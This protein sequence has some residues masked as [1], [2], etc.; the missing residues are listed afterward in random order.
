MDKFT[1]DLEIEISRESPTNYAVQL[2]F[3][4]AGAESELR[5]LKDKTEAL[6]ASALAPL[7]DLK[8]GSDQ[9]A[10]ILSEAFFKDKL[11]AIEFENAVTASKTLRTA[12]RI[13]LLL[14]AE[15]PE[16]HAIQWE[17]LNDVSGNALATRENIFFSRYLPSREIHSTRLRSNSGQL[18]ALIAVSNP[19]NLSDYS[20]PEIKVAAELKL[21]KDALKESDLT[22]VENPTVPALTA[23][24]REGF[25]IL[26]LVAHGAIVD[27]VPMV[28]LC[29]SEGK[30]D[31]V[32]GNV[33]ASRLRDLASPPR[34]IVMAVCQTGMGLHS[35]GPLFS[36]SGVPAVVAM[37]GNF[38]ME[39]NTRFMPVFF[40][41]L[42]TNGAIDRAIS[43]ARSE[44]K[45]RPDAWM[46][47]LYMRLESGLLW[48]SE[49]APV[50]DPF[51]APVKKP[52]TLRN[53]VLSAAA[54]FV[55]LILYI[56]ALPPDSLAL[57][58]SMTVRKRLPGDEL[59][60]ATRIVT[61]RLFEKNELVDLEVAAPAAGYLYVLQTLADGRIEV[62]YPVELPNPVLS[63]SQAVRIPARE[64]E[65][66][67]FETSD[68]AMVWSP[69]PIAELDD[70]LR[71]AN[72]D[73]NGNRTV[74]LPNQV[75]NLKKFL[76]TTMKTSLMEVIEGT[77]GHSHVTGSGE[78]VG[79]RLKFEIKE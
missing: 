5:L 18:K 38:S 1:S 8:P 65:Y 79:Y 34:L 28:M 43:I 62:L 54:I 45:D 78:A 22:V 24:L 31:L 76:E 36:D 26:Y 37:N 23:K 16:L 64:N 74:S 25:D 33:I 13:R 60:A 2:R 50:P 35:L 14:D 7:A 12:L 77:A 48:K 11:V 39:T 70:Q 58:Y 59:S 73:K 30:V 63:A 20:L 15:A 52:K 47:I 69:K 55:F 29:D 6:E 41:E 61:E 19:S 21:A 27:N 56:I 17:C 44:V 46:P 3:S 51:V 42:S 40:H 32:E 9:Y 71:Q 53:I 10:R 72:K 68:I 4:A 57:N 67:G 66:L 49:K 75:T